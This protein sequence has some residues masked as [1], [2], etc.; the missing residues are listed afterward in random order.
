MISFNP[1]GVGGSSYIPMPCR[2]ANKHA[3]VNVKNLRDDMCFKWAVLSAL[4][5]AT[6]HAD[7]LSKY[8]PHKNAINC[9]SLQFP[10]DPKQFS[11]FEH[12]NPEIALHCLAHDEENKCFSILRMGEEPRYELPP[13]HPSRL[14]VLSADVHVAARAGAARAELSRPRSS[15]VRLSVAW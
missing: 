15:A 9:S 10:I 12:D 2:I 3:V 8:I 5:P 11:V 1:L 6:H 14:H 7:R 13:T 4:F